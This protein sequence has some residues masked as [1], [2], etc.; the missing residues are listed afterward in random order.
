[1][2]EQKYRQH[3]Y[4]DTERTPESKPRSQQKVEN[5][6]PRAL[7]MPGS[8]AVSRCAECGTVLPVTVDVSG[9]CPKCGT[10]LHA[11]KQCAHFDPM[12][13][14]EC[15]QNVAVRITRKDAANDCD[16]YTMKVSVEKETSSAGLRADDA[17]RAFDNLFKKL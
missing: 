7:N 6:G 10:A 2:S 16:L 3:G 13:R 9:N 5:F 12:A 8:R 11:C 14:F 1:M 17:R 4:K 15:R